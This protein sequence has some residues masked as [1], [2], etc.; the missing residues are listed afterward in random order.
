MVKYIPERCDVVFLDFE[1]QT[2]KEIKKR[3]PALTISPLIYNSKSRLALF[4]PITSQIKGYPF[5]LVIE[6]GEISGAILCDQMRSFDWK[7]RKAEFHSRLSHSI[8]KEA[9]DIFETLLQ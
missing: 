1:P 8:L 2:G 5:E 4:L 9:L 7:E 6:E 3:R